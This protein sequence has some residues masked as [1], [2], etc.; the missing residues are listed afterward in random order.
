MSTID[1]LAERAARSSDPESFRRGFFAGAVSEPGEDTGGRLWSLIDMGSEAE[2]A[3]YLEGLAASRVTEELHAPNCRCVRCR[4]TMA[5][6]K[7]TQRRAVV[8]A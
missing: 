8:A 5:Q 6:R 2:V 3:G 4:S 7:R 1:W